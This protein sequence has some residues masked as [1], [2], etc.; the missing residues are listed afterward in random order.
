MHYVEEAPGELLYG[1]LGKNQ[2][3]LKKDQKRA[4]IVDIM[5]RRPRGKHPRPGISVDH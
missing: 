3:A 4:E 1:T 2:H 5:D